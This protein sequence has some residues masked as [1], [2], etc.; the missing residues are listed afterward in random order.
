M[1]HAY[2]IHC[3]GSPSA[4]VPTLFRE[5]DRYFSTCVI[6]L[7]L[8]YMVSFSIFMATTDAEMVGNDV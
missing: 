1:D 4:I 5:S 2:P 6:M 8:K 7:G 3:Y